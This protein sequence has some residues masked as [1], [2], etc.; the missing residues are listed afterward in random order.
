M[1]ELGYQLAQERG[2]ISE[3]MQDGGQSAVSPLQTQVQQDAQLSEPAD[4]A[5]AEN[6]EVMLEETPQEVEARPKPN[7]QQSFAEIRKLKEKAERERDEL[8]A[9][10]QQMQQMQQ[11]TQTEMTTPDDDL[12]IDP[13]DVVVGKHVKK[14]QKEINRLQ[15]E[16]KTYHTQSSELSAEAKLKATYPDFDA[17]VTADNVNL[18]R[19]MHPDIAATLNS[20]N[21]LYIKAAS[22]YKLIKQFGIGAADPYAQEKALAKKNAAK[23]RPTASI[24]PQAGDSPLTHANAFANGLTPDLQKQLWREMQDVRKRS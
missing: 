6:L 23:P 14:L 4:T 3:M 10:V 13:D 18:L 1:K 16:V 9:Y 21:D 11:K 15:Q 8:A 2:Q 20:S 24:S 17:V 7:P 5:P 12:E 22:A 19:E